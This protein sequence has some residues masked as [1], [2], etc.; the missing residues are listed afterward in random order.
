LLEALPRKAT[1]GTIEGPWATIGRIRPHALFASAI[2]VGLRA[3]QVL[4]KMLTSWRIASEGREQLRAKLS[5]VDSSGT[6]S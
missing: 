3:S 5:P 1:S 4:P 2:E 6:W